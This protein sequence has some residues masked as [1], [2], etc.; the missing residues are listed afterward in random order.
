MATEFTLADLKA[1][2]ITYK[3]DGSETTQD[4]FRFLVSDGTHKDFYLFPELK[5]THEGSV[6]FPIA[7]VPV[8]DEKPKVVVNKA[9]TYV[10][11]QPDGSRIARLSN[12]HLRATDRDS[13]NPELIYQIT[14]PTEH[15]ELLKLSGNV[16]QPVSRFQQKDLDKKKIIFKLNDGVTETDDFFIFT[17]ID[18]GRVGK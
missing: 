1:N 18:Q 9:S 4:Q 13:V 8:D 11:L 6:T 14:T 5:K 10:S 12:K 17:V 16:L 2:K 3:H 7:I 15:G